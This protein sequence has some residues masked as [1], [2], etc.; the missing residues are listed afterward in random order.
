MSGDFI[1]EVRKF[2][3]WELGLSDVPTATGEPESSK[4]IAPTSRPPAL[5]QGAKATTAKDDINLPSVS[6]PTLWRDF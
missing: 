1:E 5:L 2:S 4:G 3:M 6:T